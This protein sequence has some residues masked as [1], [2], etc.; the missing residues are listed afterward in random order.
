MTDSPI[1]GSAS[2]EL[3]ATRDKLKADL[4]DSEAD[5]KKSVGAMEREAGRV[6]LPLQPDA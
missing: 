5:V 6:Q 3:R 1:V 4:R 2:W